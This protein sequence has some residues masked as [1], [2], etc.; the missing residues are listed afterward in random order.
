MFRLK[1]ASDKCKVTLDPC[2]CKAS[3]A[4]TKNKLQELTKN[5]VIVHGGSKYTNWIYVV[6]SR[7]FT[8]SGLYLIVLL[9]KSDTKPP[10]REYLS[11]VR[12]IREMALKID[13]F[14][15]VHGDNFS[16][17]EDC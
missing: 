2:Q 14:S 10:D 17:L 11:F 5:N 4:I 13:H 8:L 7:V 9:K 15:R 6:L 3:N 1:P 16:N 12:Q